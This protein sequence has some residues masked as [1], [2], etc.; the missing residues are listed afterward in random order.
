[1]NEKNLIFKYIR[2][3]DNYKCI[4]L[5]LKTRLRKKVN[6]YEGVIKENLNI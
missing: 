1:M 6:Q 4:A 2:N 5:L 3:L